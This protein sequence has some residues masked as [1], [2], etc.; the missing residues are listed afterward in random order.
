M[1]TLSRIALTIG[2]AFFLT[3]LLVAYISKKKYE[4]SLKTKIYSYL[5]ILDLFILQM[6]IA[7]AFSFGDSVDPDLCYALLR[8]R[9]LLDMLYFTLLYLYYFCFFNNVKNQDILSLMRE[10][11]TPLVFFGYSL[12][13]AIIYFFIPFQKMDAETYNFMPG[14]AYYFIVLYS[15]VSTLAIILSTV[16]DYKSLPD[17]KKSSL[18][19]IV[20]FM[21]AIIIL[22]SLLPHIALLGIAGVIHLFSLY[23]VSE[24]PDLDYIEEIGKL[25]QEVEKASKTKSDFLSNMSHEIR[26]PMNAIV[27]FSETIM[28]DTRFDKER[29]YNDIKHIQS[30]SK[31]LLEIINNILDISKIESGR[32]TLEEKEYS[33]ANIC[34]E[35]S[36]I[37]D[38]RIDNKP[39][40]LEMDIDKGI[41]SR[42]YGDST[43]L[44][45]VL[46]NILTN[47]V[48]YTEVGKIRFI[49]T[50]S[51]EGPNERLKF[52]ISDTGYG[53]RKEDFDKMFEKFSRL[54]MATTNEIEGTGLG[55]VITKK[56]V[57][58]MGG[59]ITFES[60]YG[61]GT[62]F[63]VE[64]PQKIINKTP[65]GDYQE[66]TGTEKAHDKID[67]SAYRIMIV[68]DNKLNLKVA[69]RLLSEY[70]FQ[71]DTATGGKEAVYKYKE[72]THYDMIFLD[73]MMPEMDGIEVL[74]IIKKLEGYD[75]PVVVA[76]TANA[77]TGVREM[78]L[79]EGF[80]EYLSKPIDTSE[81][82]KIINKYFQKKEV[83]S[84]KS[85]K[86]SQ[87][88]TS[89]II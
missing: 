29:A 41:A 2:A 89:E 22:Q 69:Q 66:A 35:L 59:T 36:S 20:G 75:T 33:I 65:I 5:L 72:G 34:M 55:L 60:E 64:V 57:D 50:H 70:K 76:L 21:F 49:L 63:Y 42:L 28:N 67:C 83:Y 3:L 85:E 4:D 30:S 1:L 45:Q 11:R 16:K 24:N 51:A 19:I 79:K 12:F 82:N 84:L 87:N 47:A 38:A 10:Y 13:A 52:K 7:T 26:T 80:D 68:D 17:R 71:I 86:E 78:Y 8:T 25:T 27:G 23:F 39:I 14:S 9:H 6:E 58:L 37:I 43:K 77:I 48:K 74:H 46:L 61:V 53:I 32:E 54:D 73:H 56:Y 88:T 81:L 18:V 31:N 40:K 62:T 15:M 44:F